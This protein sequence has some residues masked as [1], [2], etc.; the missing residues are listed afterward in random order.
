M[1]ETCKRFSQPWPVE[2]SGTSMIGN[3]VEVTLC[4]FANVAENVVEVAELTVTISCAGPLSMSRREPFAML[5][6]VA[7]VRVATPGLT[8]AERV[9]LTAKFVLVPRNAISSAVRDSDV[10]SD[11]AFKNRT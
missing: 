5:S 10:A 7:G 4:E 1:G 8:G 2:A 9:V 3:G 6:I 11:V